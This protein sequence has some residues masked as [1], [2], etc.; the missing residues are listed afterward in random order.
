MPTKKQISKLAHKIHQLKGGTALDNWLL[1]EKTLLADESY[2]LDVWHVCPSC[3]GVLVG[4]YR[5]CGYGFDT[6]WDVRVGNINHYYENSIR[7][8][9]CNRIVRVSTN[10]F[11]KQYVKDMAKLRKSSVG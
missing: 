5:D 7:C 10:M 3:A 2:T 6:G 9:K 4:D 8:T 1:A 11:G